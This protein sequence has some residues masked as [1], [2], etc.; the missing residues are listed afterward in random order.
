[1]FTEMIGTY[2]SVKELQ[3]QEENTEWMPNENELDLLRKG[4]LSIIELEKRI[5]PKEDIPEIVSKEAVAENK[6][7]NRVKEQEDLYSVIFQNRDGTKTMYYYTEPVKYIDEKGRAQDKS[8]KLTENISD[9]RYVDKYSYVNA[10]NDIQTYF[11]KTLDSNTGIVLQHEKLKLEIFPIYKSKKSLDSAEVKAVKNEKVDITENK[12][13]QTV[14]FDGAFGEN[15]KLCYT[16]TFSGFKEDLILTEYMGMNEFSFTIKTG[17]LSLVQNADSYCFIDP[18]TEEIKVTIGDLIIYDSALPKEEPKEISEENFK[19]ISVDYKHDYNVEVVEK[20]SEY[21]LTI[22]VDEKYLIDESRVWPVTIDPSF[23]IPN[24]SAN[25]IKDVSVYSLDKNT[26]YG[27]ANNIHIGY[28]PNT[29]NRGISRTLMSFPGLT[30]HIVF[31]GMTS[32][33]TSISLKM[34]NTSITTSYSTEIRAYYYEGAAWNET[35]ATYNNIGWNNYASS[36]VCK[37][38]VSISGWYTFD[39]TNVRS[40][41]LDSTA[42]NKGLMFI[43]ASSESN[44]NYCKEF[45]SADSTIYKPYIVFTWDGAQVGGITSG[46]VY[47]IKNG[48]GSKYINAVNPP[49]DITQTAKASDPNSRNQLWYITYSGGYYKISSLGIRESSTMGKVH[50]VMT[51]SNNGI[52]IVLKKDTDADNQKWAISKIGDKYYLVNY[53]YP[54]IMLKASTSD[55]CPSLGSDYSNSGWTFEK[56]TLSNFWENSYNNYNNLEPQYTINVI[57]ES[58]VLVG[59]LNDMAIFNCATMWNITG[60]KLKIRVYKYDAANILAADLTIKVAGKDLQNKLL[61]RVCPIINGVDGNKPI[62]G[63]SRAQLDSTWIGAQIQINT[64]GTYSNTTNK[65]SV[66]LEAKQMNFLHELGHCLKLS[67]PHADTGNEDYKPLA[68][69]CQGLPSTTNNTPCRPTG[70]D[71]NNLT[72]KWGK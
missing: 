12:S 47:R 51:V 57:V 66:S 60:T 1:M 54:C 34:R 10:G 55:G 3:L 31:K 38:T 40:K 22:V 64:N 14:E 36:Y 53:A 42:A 26:K 46:N 21:I 70:H 35:D 6:H 45:Y 5:L 37:Q 4:D 62:E 7:V 29:M 16:L 59:Y 25:R 71:K 17:G 30:N 32:K 41:W 11:P 13:I 20:N 33:I 8:N 18:L 63:A 56:V 43:N 9:K 15:T 23:D 67:H 44:S 2:A 50:N 19:K 69:M 52:N 58:S 72:E 24:S 61:G 27:I 49:G 68:I 48:N 65:S 28:T 39:I